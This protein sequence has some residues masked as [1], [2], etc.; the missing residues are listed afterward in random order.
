[1]KLK[2]GIHIFSIGMSKIF[3]YVI[4]DKIIHDSCYILLYVLIR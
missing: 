1:M 2:A 4:V 3:E